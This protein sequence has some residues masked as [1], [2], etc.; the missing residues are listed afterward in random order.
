MPLQMR[1]AIRK[2]GGKGREEI[3]GKLQLANNVMG[4]LKQQSIR[5]FEIMQKKPYVVGPALVTEGHQ[6]PCSPFE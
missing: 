3:S 1:F 5:I 6:L 2:R 4:I